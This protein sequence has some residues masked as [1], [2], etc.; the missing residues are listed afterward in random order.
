M[1]I[2]STA[3]TA[4]LLDASALPERRENPSGPN[5]DGSG[6]TSM[7]ERLAAN[8]GVDV[9]KLQK[10]IDMQE[11]ILAH[12]AEAAFNAAFTLMQPEIPTI[13]ERARTDKTTYAPLEDII[14]VIRP[15]YSKHG[16]SLGFQTEWPDAKTVKVIGI[17]THTAGHARRSEFICGADQTG[18]KNAIQALGSTVSYGKRYTTKD[19]FCIV[20]REEDDD[21]RTSTKG[22]APA[23]PEGYDVWRDGMSDTADQGLAVLQT[24]FQKSKREYREYITKVEP[25]V[26][27]KIK[28]KASAVKADTK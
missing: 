8:P 14:E 10:L 7:I 26:W 4:D 25:L 24:A 28:T 18:S 19:L 13:A 2:P 3:K 12:D 17:L 5:G 23:E 22:N 16:F 21:G 27:A 1:T 20:T 9:E 15:I 11:R 6:I